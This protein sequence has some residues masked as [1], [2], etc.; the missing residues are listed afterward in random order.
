[1]H[2]LS[3]YDKNIDEIVNQDQLL[4][5]WSE[6]KYY[7]KKI[8]ELNI[9][10]STSLNSFR[11]K[12]YENL[13][14]LHLK[15]NCGFK[16]YSTKQSNLSIEDEQMNKIDCILDVQRQKCE[17]KIIKIEKHIPFRKSEKLNPNQIRFLIGEPI[18]HFKQF[19]LLSF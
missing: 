11:S 2:L 17:Q 13:N 1:L 4:I 18:L 7:P 14:E 15:D 10:K 6:L 5:D 3:F 19:P 16:T 9:M 8:F 12:C